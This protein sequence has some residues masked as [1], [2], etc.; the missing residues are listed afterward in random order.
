MRLTDPK[1]VGRVHGVIVLA[2][3]ACP[4]PGLAEER[5]GSFAVPGGVVG[6]AAFE[7]VADSGDRGL[8]VERSGNNVDHFLNVVQAAVGFLEIPPEAM[9]PRDLCQ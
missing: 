8:N 1:H 4:F 7:Q 3:V 2:G 9:G 5:A 6:A